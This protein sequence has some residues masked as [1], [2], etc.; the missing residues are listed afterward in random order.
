LI[1]R[2]KL[3]EPYGYLVKPVQERELRSTM[4]MALFKHRM[5]DS[6]RRRV[7]ELE[8][9]NR[10]SSALRSAEELSQMLPIL[11]DEILHILDIQ[12]GLIALNYPSSGEVDISE[13]RGW[14]RDTANLNGDSIK[15]LLKTILANPTPMRE[16]EFATLK[17]LAPDIRN[18]FPK[19]WGGVI[20]PI[21]AVN[22]VLGLIMV[23]VARPRVLSD[24]ENRLLDTVAEIA[25]SSIHR[26]RLHEQTQRNLQRIAALHEIDTII[27]SNLDL[28]VTLGVILEHVVQQLSVDA[29]NIYLLDARSPYLHQTAQRGL[30]TWTSVHLRVRVGEGLAGRAALER[31]RVV[32]GL[33]DFD[34]EPGERAR[35]FREE[36]IQQS[37][38]IPLLSRGKVIGVLEVFNRTPFEPDKEWLDFLGN[39]AGQAALAVEDLRL[40]ESLHH[41]NA[42]LSLAYDETIEG[43]SRAM[44]LRDRETEGHTRRV[45]EMTVELAQRMGLP[46]EMLVHIRRGVMLHD[47]GKIGVPDNILHKPGPLVDPELEI[48]RR[49]PRLAYELISP[50]AYLQPA[51]DIPYCHHEKWDGTGY[52]RGLKGE[53]IPLAARLFA[54][55]DVYDALT[56]DRPYRRRWTKQKAIR[57]LV[58]QSGKQ[59]DPH[60]IELF[61][62][63]VDDGRVQT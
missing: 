21:Q 40:L 8:A 9:V 7:A 60:I 18:C 19:G 48:M 34:Q 24:A 1:E 46:D 49:H 14:L 44:D 28:G 22:E 63:L 13:A 23:M 29:A 12:V 59:F 61:V 54:V 52:P 55:V 33:A 4:E 16:R 39:L 5:D 57:F 20:L 25:G 58:E 50:I 42:E 41:S 53:Q 10:I 51:L 2:A 3:T 62:A 26:M 30:K 43:W 11:L 45:T 35:M 38:S 32:G 17:S 27:R 6:L 47:V 56:S 15:G 36:H 31:E 37:F